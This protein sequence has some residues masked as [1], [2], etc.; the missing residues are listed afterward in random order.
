MEKNHRR[1]FLK[2]SIIG[3]SGA[4]LIPGTISSGLNLKPEKSQI[5]DLPGRVLGRTGIKASLISMGAGNSSSPGLILAAYHAGI[6]L[7]FSATYYGEGNNEKLVGEALKGFPRD[8]YFLGTAVAP[9]GYDERSGSFTSPLDVNGFIKKAE[10]SLRHFGTDYVDFILIPYASKKEA[11]LNESLLKALHELKKQGKTRFVGIATHSGSVEALKAVADSKFYDV[12][13]PAYNYKLENIEAMNEAIAYAVNAGVGIVAMKTIAGVQRDK[14][15]NNPLNTDAALKWVLQNKNI[16][17]VVSGMSSIDELQKNLTMIKN[18][19]LSDQELKDLTM[20]GIDKEPG[21]YCQQ[22]RK[23]ITQ[24]PHNLE[25]PAIMRSYMYAYGYGNLQHAQHTL[26]SAKYSEIP[27]N[28]CESCNVKCTSGFDIK[29]RVLD[30][31]RLKNVPG[32]FLVS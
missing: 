14:S 10:T 19:E 21:L 4:A 22:C 29:E 27:C 25:I 8:S 30:I 11:L 3:I 7:F 15:R 9:D 6:K 1:E 26:N 12:A 23:C 18:Q 31:S 13:M 28:Q 20:T 17:S 32:D 16:S 2:K 5:P 24:C